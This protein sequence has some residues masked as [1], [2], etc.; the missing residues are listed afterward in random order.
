M[1]M[2]Y[3]EGR[4][5]S[6]P[7]SIVFR[8]LLNVLTFL[9]FKI[10]ES[11]ESTGLIEA[12]KG[13]SFRSWGET[14][15]LSVISSNGGS[16]VNIESGVKYQVVDYGKNKENVQKILAELDNRLLASGQGPPPPPPP[17]R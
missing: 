16:Q 2:D 9:G 5:Y 3:G 1:P 14:L 15:R 7:K 8:E 17:Q 4:N 13:M 12:A 6:L 10:K 11:S